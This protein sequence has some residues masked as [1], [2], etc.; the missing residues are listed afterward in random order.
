MFFFVKL[1]GIFSKPIIRIIVLALLVSFS[2]TVLLYYFENQNNNSHYQS[3]YDFVYIWTTILTT[4]GPASITLSTDEGKFFISL[5]VLSGTFMYFA[6]F[7]ELVLSIKDRYESK[8]KGLKTFKGSNHVVIIGYNNL[9][10]GIIH[11]LDRILLPEVQ[12]VLITSKI[13]S[14]PDYERL[15]FIKDHPASTTALKKANITAAKLAIIL[16]NEEVSADKMDMNT[17]LIGGM[18]EELSPDTFT[19]VELESKSRLSAIEE[20]NIDEVITF[21]ELLEDTRHRELKP[22]ILKK[23]P[24]DLRELLIRKEY[25]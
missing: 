9:A 7:S 25:R 23:F 15:K 14:N 6:A 19:I 12:V 18:I 22:K 10:L 8:Y 5:A 24:S 13:D 11:L 20:F 4:V 16:S 1:Y 21:K 3:I 17:I 2:S